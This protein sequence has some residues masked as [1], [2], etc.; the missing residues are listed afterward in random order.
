MQPDNPW[1][2][3]PRAQTP[4]RSLPPRPVMP[5]QQPFFV[6]EQPVPTQVATPALKPKESNKPETAKVHLPLWLKIL[7]PLVAAFFIFFVVLFLT[8]GGPVLD[9]KKVSDTFVADLRSNKTSDAYAL[10]SDLFQKTTTEQALETAVSTVTPLL[11]GKQATTAEAIYKKSAAAPETAV[12]TY[13]FTASGGTEYAKTELQKDKAGKWR[14][15]NFRAN[16]QPL[17]DNIE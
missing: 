13:S 16:A 4:T 1:K 12:F 14:I 10:T 9:A 6:P 5:S 2:T 7:L 15:I 17:K 8:A 11:Q 3:P